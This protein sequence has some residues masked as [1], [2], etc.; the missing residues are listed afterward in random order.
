MSPA[1]D[2]VC[3]LFK[4][5]VLNIIIFEIVMIEQFVGWTCKMMF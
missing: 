2:E 4:T 1:N 5:K 3:F